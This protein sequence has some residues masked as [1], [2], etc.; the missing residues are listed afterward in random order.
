[1]SGTVELPAL[2]QEGVNTLAQTLVVL[3]ICFI[4]YFLIGR[5]RGGFRRF[6]GLVA[7]ARGG[8]RAG[9]VAALIFAPLTIALFYFTSLRDAAA[10]DNTI[11]AEIS[12]NGFS[13]ESGIL[14]LLVAFVKT[15]F[16]EEMLF[17]GLIAKRLINL[18]GMGLGNALHALIFG[19]VHLVIFIFPGGPAF[20]PVSALAV[21]G[22]PGAMGW[23]MAWINETKG[24]GSIAPSWL[25]HGIVNAAA[26]PV[27][28]FG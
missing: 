22:V 28:A 1:M 12:R 20:S 26:Y 27:L 5:R 19:A 17:R 2:A 16:T 13:P 9:L 10:A 14:I 3:L 8:M 4:G 11:A 23:A 6:I 7:P 18:L 25:M 15:A 21:A 24:G